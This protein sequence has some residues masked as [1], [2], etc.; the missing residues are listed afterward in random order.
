MLVLSRKINED[1]IIGDNIRLTVVTINGNRVRIGIAAPKD[2]RV[3]RA[4]YRLKN[5][6]D[7]K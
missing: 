2:V 3:D 1:I 7:A 5:E 4:E 6:K